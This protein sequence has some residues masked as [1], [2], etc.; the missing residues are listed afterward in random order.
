[1]IDDDEE[2]TITEITI[3]PD[4]RVF[5]FGTSRQVLD[6]MVELDPSSPRLRTLLHHVAAHER[7]VAAA[8]E[9]SNGSP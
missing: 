6:L 5:I 9:I 2:T 8:T 1:M 7:E 3:Q 4:G